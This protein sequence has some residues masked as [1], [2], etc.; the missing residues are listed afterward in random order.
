M[1]TPAT[2][3]AITVQAPPP[4]KNRI[5]G[6]SPLAPVR[7]ASRLSACRRRTSAEDTLRLAIEPQPS[8]RVAAK[9]RRAAETRIPLKAAANA[10]EN[11]PRTAPG[12]FCNSCPTDR[13][14]ARGTRPSQCT[15]IIQPWE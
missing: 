6:R 14:N 15:G 11:S 9:R 3:A 12:S 1:A 4:A 13:N 5:S 10:A 7:L 8:V 2:A